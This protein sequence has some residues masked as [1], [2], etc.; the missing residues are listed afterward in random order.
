[1]CRMRGNRLRSRFTGVMKNFNRSRC[2]KGKNFATRW[3]VDGT[4]VG[5]EVFFQRGVVIP[6]MMQVTSTFMQL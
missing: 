5:Y 2:A 3:N 4:A 6:T 1:M